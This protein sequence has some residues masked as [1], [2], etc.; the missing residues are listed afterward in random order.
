MEQ[1][2]KKL[3]DQVRDAIR[4]KHYSVRIEEARVAW[5]TRY[6]L[7]HDKRHLSEMGRVEVEAFLLHLA[8]KGDVAAATQKQAL[9]GVAWTGKT[10]STIAT[11]RC[12]LLSGN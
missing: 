4:L 10:P 11:G 9:L 12:K 5:I 3:L 6:I 8:M 2:P 7:F 1:R